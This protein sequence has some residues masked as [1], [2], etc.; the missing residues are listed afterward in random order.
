MT[1]ARYAV[2]YAA[3]KTRFN[4]TVTNE[5]TVQNFLRVEQR[6]SFVNLGKLNNTMK[7][8]QEDKLSHW[9]AALTGVGVGHSRVLNGRVEAYTMKRAG[10]DKKYAAVLGEKYVEQIHQDQE[11]AAA[12][13]AIAAAIPNLKRRKRSQ[14][15]GVLDE[16]D[17]GDENKREDKSCKRKRSC[18]FDQ[19]VFSGKRLTSLGDFTEQAT[20]RLM[21][22][23][24]LTLNASFPDYDFGSIKTTDFT[25]VDVSRVLPTINNFLSEWA[26]NPQSLSQSKNPQGDLWEAINESVPLKDCDVYQFQ[27]PDGSLMT[28]WEEEEEDENTS[29][30]VLWSF[31]YLFVNKAHKRILLF[32]ATESMKAITISDDDEDTEERYIGVT[33]AE[34]DGGFDLDPSSATP[35]GIPISSI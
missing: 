28:A 25:K 4:N 35:G 26:R 2:V 17:K 10:S 18:S 24:I 21:T 14:S 22:D 9:T 3:G 11:M 29:S 27:P 34:A 8:L 33:E 12:A 31:Y 5:E 23:L 20:R 15:A 1:P 30:T 32:T 16:A 6:H 19:V 7:Y 13:A